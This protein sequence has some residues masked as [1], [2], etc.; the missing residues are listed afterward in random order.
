M[1]NHIILPALGN[2][3]EEAEI[4]EWLK[5]EGDIVKEGEQVVLI[6]TPK[7]TVELEAPVTGRLTRIL[8][9]AGELVRVGAK[10]GVVES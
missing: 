4:S 1:D 2:E 7:V 8:V 3:I 6:T 10:L 9:P 5:A